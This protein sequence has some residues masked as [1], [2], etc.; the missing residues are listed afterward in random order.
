MNFVLMIVNVLFALTGL[1]FGLIHG[2]HNHGRLFWAGA[3][4]LLGLFIFPVG[5]VAG[6]LALLWRGD[7][8]ERFHHR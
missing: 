6:S 3:A 8:C 7:A 4:S 2:G 1:Y 5:V